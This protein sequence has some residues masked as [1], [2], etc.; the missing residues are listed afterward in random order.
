MVDW[1]AF[2]VVLAIFRQGSLVGAAS[3]LSVSRATASRHLARAEELL[4]AKLFDRLDTGMFA[5]AAGLIAIR[6][7]EKIE[8]EVFDASRML[9]GMDD[10][11]VGTI[12]I[13]VPLHVL[14]FGLSDELRQFQLMYPGIDFEIVAS[15]ARVDFLDRDIDLVIRVDNNPSAGLWGYKI[16]DIRFAFF[17]KDALLAEWMEEMRNAPDTSSVP[18][19]AS[20]TSDVSQ[21]RKVFLER[22]PNARTVAAGNGLD[23]MIPLLRSGFGFGR[24][25]TYVARAFP[26]LARVPGFEL[27]QNRAMWVLTHPDFRRTRRIRLLVE[28]LNDQFRKRQGEFT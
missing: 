24:L 16:A 21:D 10:T 2:R 8:R 22:F 14:P 6:H 1:D 19:I 5:T 28:F 7:A 17:G 27:Q 11:E 13:S 26:E 12:R 9:T 4:G 25:A 20:T 3:E 23:T 15:D 18:F